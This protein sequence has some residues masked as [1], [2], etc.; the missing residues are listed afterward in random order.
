MTPNEIRERKRTLSHFSLFRGRRHFLRPKKFLGP[1]G[2]PGL[3]FFRAEAEEPP[4]QK[5][6]G[7]GGREHCAAY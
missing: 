1:R 2:V 7:E 6:V 5:S 4:R 3:P